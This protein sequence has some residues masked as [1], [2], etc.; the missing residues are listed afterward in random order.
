[1]K[2]DKVERVTIILI[3]ICAAFAAV[4]MRSV[5]RCHR[6]GGVA[7]QEQGLI[8]RKPALWHTCVPRDVLFFLHYDR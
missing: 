6:A 5:A 2:L 3:V 7:I 8:F 1:M 4:Q